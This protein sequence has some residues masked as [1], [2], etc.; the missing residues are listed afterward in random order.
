MQL[1]RVLVF[2]GD[3]AGANG[4]AEWLHLARLGFGEKGAG[5]N[6]CYPIIRTLARTAKA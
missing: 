3:C 1:L 4:E 2:G 6:Q 5:P